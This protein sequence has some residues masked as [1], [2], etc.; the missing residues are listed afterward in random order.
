M[1]KFGTRHTACVYYIKRQTATAAE[2]CKWADTTRACTHTHV[3][4]LRFTPTTTTKTTATATTTAAAKIN[5]NKWCRAIIYRHM[6]QCVLLHSLLM[7]FT[8]CNNRVYGGYKSQ[9]KHRECIRLSEIRATQRKRDE[10]NWKYFR[11]L[12]SAFCSNYI[13]MIAPFAVDK[14]ENWTPNANEICQI[15]SKCAHHT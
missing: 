7:L 4:D 3:E 15:A 1:A 10:T 14:Q 13:R 12:V 8:T 9:L 2:K 11:E 6:L 5:G